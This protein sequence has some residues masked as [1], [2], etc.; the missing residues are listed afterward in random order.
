MIRSPHFFLRVDGFGA[1]FPF[2]FR[3]LVLLVDLVFRAAGLDLRVL[4]LT[5]SRL[6]DKS[7][8]VLLLGGS[9]AFVIGRISVSVQN[10]VHPHSRVCLL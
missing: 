6:P 2:V 4:D 8:L 3:L 5:G 7:V 1:A 10:L 9:F